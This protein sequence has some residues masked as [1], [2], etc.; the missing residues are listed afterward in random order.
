MS[1]E[2]FEPAGLPFRFEPGTPNMTGAV[3]LLRAIQYFESIGGYATIAD[4]ESPLVKYALGRFAEYG[5]KLRLIGSSS[6]ENRLGVFS[7]TVPGMHT[8]DIADA[9]AESNI[10]VR[11][12]HHCTEPF[13]TMLGIHSSLRMSL[14]FYNTKKDVDAFFVA[15]NRSISV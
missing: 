12:G 9:L 7:F 3:S 10:C 15:L 2:T 4:L 13:H 14:Y 8:N 1:R 11:A 5:P 6:S